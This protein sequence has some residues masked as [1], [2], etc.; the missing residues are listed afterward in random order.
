MAMNRVPTL[1]L[2]IG[3]IGCRMA[4]NVAD[5]LTEEDRQYVG[6]VGMDTNVNDLKQLKKRG[7]RTIQTSDERTVRDFITEHFYS[8][9]WFPLN[10]FTAGKSL[11]NGAGQIRA[12]S[13][14]AAIAAEEQGKFLPIKEEIQRIRK[15]DGQL[16]V[17]V[18]GSITGGTGAGLF[19]QIPYYLRKVMHD[20]SGR[21]D[22]IIRGMFVGPDMTADVQPSKINRDAVHVNGYACLKELNALYLRENGKP[23]IAPLELDFYEPATKEDIEFKRNQLLEQ[24]KSDSLADGEDWAELVRDAET[25]AAGN[26][27][28]PYDY[29]YLIE[30]SN[31]EGTIGDAEL[32]NVEELVGRIVHTLMFTPVRDNALSVEDNM[33]LQDMAT[34]GMNRYS[35]AG[36][37]RLVYPMEIAREYVTLA[38]VRDMVREEWLALDE[39]YKADVRAARD[40]QKSNTNVVIPSCSDSYCKNFKELVNSGESSLGRLGKE[41]FYKKKDGSM[42]VKSDD[43]IG[44]I[45]DEIK[46]VTES[47]EIK[48]A[49]GKCNISAKEMA[50]AGAAESLVA[51][52]RI[53]LAALETA[54][55]SAIGNDTAIANKLF[56]PSWNLMAESRKD[57]ERRTNI[58]NI[59]YKV[60]PITARFLCYSLIQKLEAKIDKAEEE[61]RKVDLMWFEKEEKQMDYDS[62]KEGVQ[63]IMTGLSNAA[64]TEEIP[65][66]GEFLASG[67]LSKIASI[68]TDNVYIQVEHIQKYLKQSLT[69]RTCALLKTRLEMLSENYRIFFDSIAEKIRFN[70]ARIAHLEKMNLPLG[71]I[72]VYCTKEAFETMAAEFRAKTDGEMQLATKTAV[73]EQLYTVFEGEFANRGKAL[74]EKQKEKL[75]KVKLASLSDIFEK[76]VVDTVRTSVVED[77]GGIVDITVRQAL[78]KEYEL[79][80]PDNVTEERYIQERVEQAMIKAAPMLAVDTNAM[81]ENTQTVYMA[82]NPACADVQISTDGLRAEPSASATQQAM[83]PASGKATDNLT[84]TVLMKENFSPYEITCMKARYKFSID[85]LVKYKEGSAA[86][87]CYEERIRKI[88]Q[89]PL[90]T[91]NPDDGL[92]V[93]PPHLNRH[94]HEEAYLPSIYPDRQL[95]NEKELG[96]AFIY[97]LGSDFF[98]RENSGNLLDPKTGESIL[99]WFYLTADGTLAPL[100]VRSNPVG[101]SYVDLY[102]ALP[103]LG[104]FKRYLMKEK[105]NK[106]LASGKQYPSME[107]REAYLLENSFIKDL[108]QKTKPADPTEKN[109]E[110]NI[111]DILLDMRG[112]LE[113]GEWKDLFDALL[114]VLQNYCK[115]LYNYDAAGSAAEPVIN[116]SVRTILDSALANS[117]IGGKTEE[118]IDSKDFGGKDLYRQYSRI[119]NMVFK[120]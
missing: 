43:F 64:R 15:D 96:Y 18:V 35:S 102:R 13:R 14:L 78:Q 108:V 40:E 117:V 32:S 77:G 113:S 5:L 93:V 52:T 115:E 4:A 86:H 91:G 45:D 80:M 120:G 17:M 34:R 88:G 75:A 36:I 114:Y 81:A 98:L 94:W 69:I 19:L 72:G 107:E 57:P 119:R 31:S 89:S 61:F 56:P 1:V 29:V 53:N 37:C 49:A 112:S 62:S 51:E 95:R 103:Y 92:T 99:G 12:V 58:Y 48:K 50:S 84:P 70:D 73:F 23:G 42:G 33:V 54:A 100:T 67:K 2:G 79:A 82:I 118:T 55:K 76:A 104:K 65:L 38:T 59:L 11:L 83:I 66:I 116:R 9:S 30:N 24:L 8:N 47:E 41:A 63:D 21:S 28:L 97:A 87:K 25:L 20:A 22:I 26:P 109:A 101:T 6:V 44:W 46:K 106:S 74:T 111:F 90:N 3:G 105:A 85:D 68:F 60:H 39:R 71:Q 110:G 16:T 27:A 7:M 10:R